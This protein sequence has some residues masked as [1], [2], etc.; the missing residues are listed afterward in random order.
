[1]FAAGTMQ[2][3]FGLGPHFDSLGADRTYES[4]RVDSSQP[5][6]GQAT[7]NILFDMGVR[8]ATPKGVVL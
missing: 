4:P 7:Y 6:I 2:W 1:M 3:S 8:P 5:V